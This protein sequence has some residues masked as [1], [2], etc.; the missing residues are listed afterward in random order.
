MLIAAFALVALYGMS[1]PVAAVFMVMFGIGNGLV[2]IARGTV[3]IA[4]LN[5]AGP[6]M[7]RLCRVRV[8]PERSVAG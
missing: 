3:P 5:M 4:K 7:K 1:V 6:S 8:H 2:T